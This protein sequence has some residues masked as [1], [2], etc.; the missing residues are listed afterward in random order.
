MSR[1]MMLAVGTTVVVPDPGTGGP[2]GD[3]A[4]FQAAIDSVAPTGGIVSFS[5]SYEVSSPITVPGGVWLVGTGWKGSKIRLAN[6]ANC[7]VIRTT[8]GSAVKYAG[9]SGF[10]IDGNRG[11]NTT[12][13]GVHFDNPKPDKSN[14]E[15]SV[16]IVEDVLVEFAAQDAFNIGAG[17]VETRLFNC[18]T[19]SAGRD[20]FR[21]NGSDYWL[22]DC[23]SGEAG[24]D[25]F[26]L[27]GQGARLSGCKSWWSGR[28]SAPGTI[29]NPGSG[30]G[31]S[32]G[33]RINVENAQITNCEAQD[34]SGP[35]A[36][37]NG[38]SGRI[39]MHLDGNNG[40]GMGA[41]GYLLEVAY[42]T[43][44]LVDVNVGYGTGR[45][46]A[47]SVLNIGPQANGNRVDLWN[48][49]TGNKLYR[50]GSAAVGSNTINATGAYS[51]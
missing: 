47:P 5:G 22:T 8:P 23:T 10:Y 16:N 40:A 28:Q 36:I 11:N 12:G 25:G 46:V 44:M 15:C 14:G 38:Y 48:G 9:L 42:A 39:Q 29:G 1:F 34:S 19:Y 26:S 49:A 4:L 41:T 43:N 31:T 24:G 35:G 2:T 30:N 18:Y 51:A 17:Q 3:A 45:G 32:A 21:I 6:G 37:I 33:F 20:G 27:S 7:D 50:T 13:H